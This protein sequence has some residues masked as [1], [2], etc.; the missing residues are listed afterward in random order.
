MKEIEHIN[1]SVHCVD[2]YDRCD[3]RRCGD[4]CVCVSLYSIPFGFIVLLYTWYRATRERG[5]NTFP[6]RCRSAERARAIEICR[7]QQEIA[8]D[9]RCVL[10]LVGRLCALGA[11]TSECI[12]AARRVCFVR[13]YFD[14]PRVEHCTARCVAYVVASYLC[15]MRTQ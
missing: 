8:T 10:W 13:I 2:Y 1:V 4:L 15:G 9:W 12:V 7:A 3:D 6:C 14:T 5:T 11:H